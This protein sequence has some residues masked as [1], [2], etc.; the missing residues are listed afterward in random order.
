MAL[1]ADRNTEMKGAELLPFPMAASTK[2]YAGGIVATDGGY[3]KN[4]QAGTTLKYQGRAEETVDNSAGANGDKTV[5]VRRGKAF[6]WKNSAGDPV[7]Q[8]DVGNVCYIEDDETIAKT[9]GTGT[10]SACGTILAVES[11][12]VWVK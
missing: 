1:S 2:V 12:G 9:D 3:A 4:G 10:L 6:K 7:A 5:M 8:A 11:D